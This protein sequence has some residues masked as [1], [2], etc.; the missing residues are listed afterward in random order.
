MGAYLAKPA[1][2]KH[3]LDGMH[4]H[5][6]TKD[7]RCRF[8]VSEMQG[9]RKNMED[10]FVAEDLDME[11]TRRRIYGVFDG[12]GGAEVSRFVAKRFPEMLG[13]A[14]LETNKHMDAAL[15]RR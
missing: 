6:Q 5:T 9:W 11:G 7:A 10:A 2:E 4:S 15:P 1:L 8:G 3:P 14:L 13:R 12:H